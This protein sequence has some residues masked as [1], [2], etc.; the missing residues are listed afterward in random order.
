MIKPAIFVCDN[1]G[2]ERE[3]DVQPMRMFVPVPQRWE[4]EIMGSKE[5]HFC[6][7]RCRG[8]WLV[9]LQLRPGVKQP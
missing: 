5:L 7:S 1:C 6:G 8:E 4:T 2:K 3:S 9:K